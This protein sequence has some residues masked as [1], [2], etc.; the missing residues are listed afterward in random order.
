MQC[1]GVVWYCNQEGRS[2][3]AGIQMSRDPYQNSTR[4][5]HD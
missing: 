4:D 3:L 5:F 1:V 2:Y